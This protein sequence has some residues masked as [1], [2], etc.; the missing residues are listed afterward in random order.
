[1]AAIDKIYGSR[2][3]WD[4]IFAWLTEF[5][6]NRVFEMYERPQSRDLD[7]PLSN[8]S[9]ET[10]LFLWNHCD[11]GLVQYRL[12]QQYGPAGPGKLII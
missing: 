8:F 3:E 2:E 5:Y 7:V 4:Q 1:M 9:D 11:M 12:K 10:N 6:P